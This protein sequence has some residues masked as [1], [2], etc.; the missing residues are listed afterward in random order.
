MNKNNE[1]R[2][3]IIIIILIIV[4]VGMS[5][6]ITVDKF[7]LDTN[8]KNKKENPTST[9]GPIP[10]KKPQPTQGE[11]IQ[12]PG[13][14]EVEISEELAEKIYNTF[15][16]KES[17]GEV[18]S[19][20]YK[21]D[22]VT[23]NNL[24]N[25]DKNY[26]IGINIPKGL[27]DILFTKEEIIQTKNKLFGENTPFEIVDNKNGCHYFAKLENGTYELGRYCGVGMCTSSEITDTIKSIKKGNKIYL[28]QRVIFEKSQNHDNDNGMTSYYY[29]DPSRTILLE[30]KDYIDADEY[31]EKFNKIDWEKYENQVSV[32]RY[33]YQDNGDGT[34]MFI[35]MK[36]IK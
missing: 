26:I 5:G 30:K 10:S 16:D 4:I 31:L 7:L 27:N 9:N 24:T 11:D 15:Y 3:T 13:E 18:F 20:Y 21:Y 22:I 32:Y 6:F 36:K 34:Y 12:E 35:Q 19:K 23:A 29:Q 17:C 33:T 28:E 14:E 1:K 25:E 8:S 2:L